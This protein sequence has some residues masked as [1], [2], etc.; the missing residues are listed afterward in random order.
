MRVSKAVTLIVAA[1]CVGLPIAGSILFVGLQFHPPAPVEKVEAKETG[2]GTEARAGTGRPAF[3][4]EEVESYL[5]KWRDDP[6]AQS[7][8]GLVVVTGILAFFTYRLF[9]STRDMAVE[10]KVA[11]DKALAA[12]TDATNTLVRVERPYVTVGGEYLRDSRG[13]LHLNAAG[14]RLFRLEVGNYGKTA[15][16]LTAFD[17]RFESLANV[18]GRSSDVGTTKRLYQDLLEPGAV[19]KVIRGDIV[20]TVDCLSG[21]NVAYG[22]CWYRSA[23]KEGEHKSSFV[24]KLL[25]HRTSIDEDV[26]KLDGSY[27]HWD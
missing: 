22:A 2:V 13:A 14:Q 5:E 16:I 21:K 12:S 20:I 7:T 18:Q 15:A 24:L 10:T 11:S 1:L 9:K 26:S 6:V 17:V 4:K 27:R 23:L 19:S 3:V 25:A 8:L